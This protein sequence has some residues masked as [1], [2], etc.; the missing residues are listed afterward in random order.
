MGDRIWDAGWFG[1]TDARKNFPRHPSMHLIYTRSED[2]DA[3]HLQASMV[4]TK[5]VSPPGLETLRVPLVANLARG[6][7]GADGAS[8]IAPSAALSPLLDGASTRG[9]RVAARGRGRGRGR[10]L[11]RRG[12]VPPRGR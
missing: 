5:A 4:Y 8:R 9:P 3:L 2:F 7:P 6:R 10:F 11:T 12:R 1:K